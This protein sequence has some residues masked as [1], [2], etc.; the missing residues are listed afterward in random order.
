MRSVRLALWLLDR[1]GPA[2]KRG[3]LSGDLLEEL[4]GGRTARWFWYQLS[5]AILINLATRM[6]RCATMLAFAMGWTALYP[7][8]R[9][10]CVGGL[11]YSL[12]RHELL[13]WPWSSFMPIA[14]GVLP[15]VLLVWLGFATYMALSGSTNSYSACEQCFALSTGTTMIF[16]ASFAVLRQLGH[17]QLIID[18]VT[19][20]DFFLIDHI[21]FISIPIALTLWVTLWIGASNTPHIERRQRKKSSRWWTCIVRTAQILSF[22]LTLCPSSSAQP[23]RTAEQTHGTDE[24]LVQTLK[25]KLTEEAAAG[26]FSGAVL[27]AK[28]GVPLFEQAYGLADREQTISNTIETRFRI[29]SINKVLTA[30]AIMQLA[31]AGKIKLDDPL[32]NYVPDYP[33]KDLAQKVTIRE[34]LNHTGGTGDVFG[35]GPNQLFSEEYRS[36]RLQ[37]KTLDDYIHLYGDRPLRFVPGSRFEYSNYGYILLGKVI[38]KTS[39]ENYYDYMRKHVY[40]PARMKSTG[41]LPVEKAVTDLSIGY[42]TMDVNKTAQANTDTLPYRGIPAGMGYSTVRDLLAFA[43]ALQQHKLLDS[44]YTSLMKTGNVEMPRDGSYGY[45]LMVHPLNGIT[46]IGHAG[47]YPGMNADVELCNDSKY[48]VVVLANVDPPV[49]QRLGFFIANW[50]TQSK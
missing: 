6:N 49:A 14:Y 36:H 47:G 12:D 48:V 21:Y 35:T 1:M 27:V 8:W 19:R 10:I 7:L 9:D 43:M 22:A 17:P 33:N 32:V 42:T 3:N 4:E 16:A 38:E 45:G 44:H 2:V 41:E 26:K 39:R 28:D 25:A 20:T 50:V 31:E 34:L 46:C 15:A 18:D 29:G 40:G 5:S 13:A 37:L 23:S 11:T 24:E 30:V